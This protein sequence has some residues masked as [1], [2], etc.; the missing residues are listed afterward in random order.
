[1]HSVAFTQY[2]DSETKLETLFE[3]VC[4]FFS[5]FFFLFFGG[6]GGVFLAVY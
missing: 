5:S 2:G 4:G 1:M 3:L 6:G